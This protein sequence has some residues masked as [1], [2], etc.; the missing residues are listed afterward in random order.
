ML[1]KDKNNVITNNDLNK[2][3]IILVKIPYNPDTM[4]SFSQHIGD[5]WIKIGQC[6]FQAQYFEL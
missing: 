2:T 4:S 1:V 6:Q 3:V 5:C